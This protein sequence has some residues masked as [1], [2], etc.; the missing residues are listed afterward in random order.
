MLKPKDFDET[1]GSYCPKSVHH[2]SK[3]LSIYMP[4]CCHNDNVN[5]EKRVFCIYAKLSNFN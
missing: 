1:R 5:V 2:V 3:I 4:L